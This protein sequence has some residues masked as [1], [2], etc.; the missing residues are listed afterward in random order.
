MGA[1]SLDSRLRSAL[2]LV[3]ELE[4]VGQA[5]DYQGVRATRQLAVF[6][7]HAEFLHARDQGARRRHGRNGIGIAVANNHRDVAHPFEAVR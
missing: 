7:R 2:M 5:R 6:V 3:E 1:R 4:N